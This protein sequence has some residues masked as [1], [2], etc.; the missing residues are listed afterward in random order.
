[1]YLADIAALEGDTETALAG[2]RRLTN[3]IAGS[4]GPHPR[5]RVAARSRQPR[6]ALTLLDDYVTEH[7]ERGFEMTLTKANLLAE[8]GEADAGLAILSSAME[9]HPR[10]PALEY[11]RAVLLEK[12]GE[13]RESVA[14]L[15]RLL[16]ERPGDP[17]LLNALGYTLADH[18][19]RLSTPKS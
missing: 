17:T 8:H 3:S 16:S 6:E 14:V 13:V 10:H 2:Y 11:D 18:G 9:Q 4:G 7:P 5:C 19:M 1:M 12:Q 15:E